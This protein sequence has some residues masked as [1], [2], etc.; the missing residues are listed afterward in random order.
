M[1]SEIVMVVESV[2]LVATLVGWLYGARRMDFKL[3]HRLVYPSVFIHTITVSLWMIPNAIGQL[4]LI[5]SDPIANWYK[6]VHDILGFI[7]IALGIIISVIYLIR[8]DMPLKLLKKT[9]PFM[10]ATLFI[11]T[12]SFI[13]GMYWFILIVTG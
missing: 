7:G 9:R 4:P 6:I 12:A 11:W 5:M 10:F 1:I 2:L 3:H 8:R 13:L